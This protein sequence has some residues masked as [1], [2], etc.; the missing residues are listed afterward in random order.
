MTTPCPLFAVGTPLLIDVLRAIERIEAFRAAGDA[1][2]ADQWCAG[3]RARIAHHWPL[4]GRG[5]FARTHIDAALVAALL[6]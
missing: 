6:D 5:A 1:A 2:E 4:D 3:L